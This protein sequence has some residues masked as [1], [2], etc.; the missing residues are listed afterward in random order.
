MDLQNFIPFIV[1]FLTGMVFSWFLGRLRPLLTSVRDA[2]A[3]RAKSARQGFSLNLEKRYRQD[4]LRLAQGY[5]L[6]AALFSLEEVLVK[7]RVMAPPP[8]ITPGEAPLTDDSISMALPYMPD[9][10]EL[11]GMLGAPTFSLN[12]VLNSGMNIALIGR[13]GSGKTV[14]LAALASQV[15]R[16]DPETEALN[17]R[18]P[19]LVHVAD[20]SNPSKKLDSPIDPIISAL[21]PKMSAI[22]EAGLGGYLRTVFERGE[23]LL[24]LDGLDELPPEDH[25][26]YAEYLAAILNLYPQTQ[27]VAAAAPDHFGILIDLGFAPLAMAAW[28]PNQRSDFV[29][30]WEELW[31]SNVAYEK[32]AKDLPEQIPAPLVT[33]WLKE[34][35][36]SLNPLILTLKV[37][38]VYA[39]DVLGAG[40]SE[41]IEAFIRR[42]T[43]S[44]SGSRPALEQLAMQMAIN[45]TPMVARRDA[46]R[47]V[48]EFEDP[49][50]LDNDPLP[51]LEPEPEEEEEI[52]VEEGETP[53]EELEAEEGEDLEEEIE[54]ADLPE[55]LEAARQEQYEKPVS[56]RGVRRMLPELVDMGVMISRADSRLS[57]ANPVL[58]GYLAACGIGHTG[59]IQEL[60]EQTQ[61]VGRSLTLEF[62]PK[63]SDISVLIPKMVAAQNVD[64]LQQGLLDVARWPRHASR[65]APWRS[66][67]MRQLAGILQQA[68][69]PVGVRA[70]LLS[71]LVTSGDPGVAGLFRQLLAHSHPTVR[72]LAA[73]GCG[74]MRD[75]QAVEELTGVFSDASTLVR[76][77]SCIALAAIGTSAAI[78]A[79]A[80]A[81][82]SGDEDLRRAAAEALASNPNEGHPILKEGAELDDLLVRRAV[83]YGL[84]KVN[85]S[86]A[87]D[88]LELMRVEDEQWVVRSAASEAF[89]MLEM[90]NPRIPVVLPELTD[91]PWLIAFA[92]ER[93]MGVAPGTAWQTLMSALRDGDPEEKLAAMDYLRRS[94]E[95][96]K[97][98][99]S[100]LYNLLYGSEEDLSEAA[101]NTLWQVAGAGVEL[102][103]PMQFGLG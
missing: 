39:G 43:A 69:Y 2:I 49:E 36:S 85:E 56:G 30:R 1:G 94:P 54:L 96:A 67:L 73:L 34:D 66:N 81:L 27:V 6:A 17:T 5:H 41:A 70:K 52:E 18:I 8:S 29:T 50:G 60:S 79:V 40:S 11:G 92:G 102:P 53:E 13:P 22:L 21:A 12:E 45:A 61:W 37:W 90:D 10:P 75:P 64:P 86:W 76:Q 83:V 98:A 95:E 89:D 38:A 101:L 72:H 97:S 46:G 99:F 28:S 63:R 88:I 42:V 44:A 71:A 26:T 58:G 47:F 20:L 59:G 19:V 100:E 32:W 57:F 24:L 14:A 77:S 35:T 23:A 51:E 25:Q 78:E 65:K 68:A 33:S 62:L 31:D 9:W 48:S 80:D 15:A 91:Q 7:P 82:L 93:G 4:A 84:V 87:K 3:N 16:R 103:A 74:A 55:E